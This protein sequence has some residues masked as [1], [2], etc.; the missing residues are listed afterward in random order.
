MCGAVMKSVGITQD[1]ARKVID[2]RQIGHQ[3]AKADSDLPKIQFGSVPCLFQGPIQEP[4]CQA[5]S[6]GRGHDP[7]LS[8]S[9]AGHFSQ[10]K[11]SLLKIYSL[12]FWLHPAV[13]SF[14]SERFGRVD[15]SGSESRDETREHPGHGAHQEAQNDSPW[16][17]GGGKG[18]QVDDHSHTSDGD[19]VSHD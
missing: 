4:P 19:D 9:P 12:R 8:F 16:C 17:H 11:S 14:R 3:Y 15:S 7:S 13:V 5:V 6:Y 18:C 1:Q 10:V 2:I